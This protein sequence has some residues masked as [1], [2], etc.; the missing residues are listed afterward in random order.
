[1]F[2]F[3]KVWGDTAMLT[4]YIFF[5]LVEMLEQNVFEVASLMFVLTVTPRQSIKLGVECW[6]KD[7]EGKF[8]CK[9]TP[10]LV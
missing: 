6:M 2:S 7:G 5:G 10:V 4:L 1:M 3:S 8:G 9:I